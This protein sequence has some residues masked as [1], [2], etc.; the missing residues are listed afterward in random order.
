MS[1]TLDEKSLLLTM[2]TLHD[3]VKMLLPGVER[4]CAR[5]DK[6]LETE[7]DDI[8]DESLPERRD[9]FSTVLDALR[10]MDPVFKEAVDALSGLQAKA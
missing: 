2:K 9:A 4:E 8:A 6:A 10:D 7:D 1:Q 3:S 5:L